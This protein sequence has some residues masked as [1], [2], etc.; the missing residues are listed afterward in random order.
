MPLFVFYKQSW[1]FHHFRK[2]CVYPHWNIYMIPF[3]FLIVGTAHNYG[4]IVKFHWISDLSCTFF[5]SK[6]QVWSLVIFLLSLPK[7]AAVK[8]SAQVWI[9]CCFYPWYHELRDNMI[10]FSQFPNTFTASIN[11]FLLDKGLNSGQQTPLIILPS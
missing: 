6:F 5:S 7:S 9:L 1:S 2:F 10:T 3:F 8:S 4:F 11:F